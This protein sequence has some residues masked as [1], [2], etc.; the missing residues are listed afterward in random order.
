MVL[1]TGLVFW[2][3]M[4]KNKIYMQMIMMLAFSLL[5][6]SIMS[7]FGVPSDFHFCEAQSAIVSFFFRAAWAWATMIIFMLYS[8]MG[9][10]KMKVH[11][12]VM[13]II[14]WGVN[15]LIEFLPMTDDV[16]YGEDDHRLGK[17][18]CSLRG[19]ETENNRSQKIKTW[20]VCK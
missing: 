11:F 14:L 2:E 8:Y 4:V 15:L 3:H 20:I 1:L 9:T 7:A 5:I 16:Y 17:T 12:T 18:I 10:G 13:N 19:D 6:A